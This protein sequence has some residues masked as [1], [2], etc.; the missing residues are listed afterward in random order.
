MEGLT[1]KEDESQVDEKF[2]KD[3]GWIKF[4]DNGTNGYN[5]KY[6][7][8]FLKKVE[9]LQDKLSATSKKIYVKD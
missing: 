7:I 9:K 1:L 5:K 8:S 3:I 4:S 6:F 2:Q